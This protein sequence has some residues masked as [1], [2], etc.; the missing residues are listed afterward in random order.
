MKADARPL[1]LILDDSPFLALLL[2]Q[3]L[4][5]L[6]LRAQR[7]ADREEL[8]TLA[9]SAVVMLIE[10]Q[11]FTVNGFQVTRELAACCACPLILLSGTGRGTDQHW[12]L[13]AGAQAVLVRPVQASA[14]HSALLQLGCCGETCA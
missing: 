2:A 8:L 7:L 5:A 14:L 4:G 1:A 6:G 3:Q 10:L 13:R 9:G 12:G 11:Q